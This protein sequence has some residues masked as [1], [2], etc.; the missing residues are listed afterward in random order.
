MHTLRLSIPI[1]KGAR[2]GAVERLIDAF[3]DENVFTSVTEVHMVFT[4][5]RPAAPT[6]ES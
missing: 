5:A 1:V 3:P 2:T 6:L 4:S